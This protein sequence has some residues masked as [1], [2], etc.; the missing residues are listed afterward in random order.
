MVRSGS[1]MD[2]LVLMGRRWADIQSAARK[3]TKWVKDT[4]HL[5]I[6]DS[7]VR[8]DFLSPAEEHRRRHLKGAA[9]GC[10]GLDMQGMSC[11]APILPFA[12]VFLSEHGGSI[13]A[14]GQTYSAATSFRFTVP[15][16]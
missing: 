6:K 15:T 14:Q 3:I 9:K 10:P 8:V 4:L 7:W 11:T 2:D 12:R 13:C 5:T 16:A 1:Y